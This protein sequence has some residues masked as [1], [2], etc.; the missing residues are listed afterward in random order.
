[1]RS[2]NN[3][4]NPADFTTVLDAIPTL[5]IRKWRDVDVQ[6]LFEIMYWCALRPIEA[7]HLKKE[8]FD[9]EV[10]EVYLGQTKTIKNDKAPIPTIFVTKLD[11][12]LQDKE[13]G[14]LLPGLTY[15]TFYPWLKRLGKILSIPA[16]ITPQSETGEKTVGHIFRKSVGKDMLSGMYGE[17]AKSIPIISQ[18]LRHSSP[19]VTMKHY[20]KSSIEAVKEAW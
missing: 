6:M 9:L 15:N 1:V 4:L 13:P 5:M 18:Q 10:R 16:W 20:L 3:Y 17:K 11:G 12:Y 19:E 7:I 8:D 2:T 14:R